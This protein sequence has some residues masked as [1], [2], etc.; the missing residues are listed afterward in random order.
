DGVCA[1]VRLRYAVE[2][3]PLDTAGAI[4]FAAVAAGIG[5]E[6]FVAV[7]GDVLTDLDVAAMVDL[8]R[9][10]GAEGTLHPTSVDDP[11]AFGVVPT[12]GDGRVEAF[13]E[14]PPHG[15]APTNHVN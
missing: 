5:A 15:S 10:R 6:T 13:I 7:N 9:R 2:E 14:K 11:A 8:H 4:R 12:D 3:E 1:G